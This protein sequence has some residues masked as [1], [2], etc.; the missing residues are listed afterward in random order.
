VLATN[1]KDRALNAESENV[2]ALM[3]LKTRNKEEYRAPIK[4]NERQVDRMQEL[5]GQWS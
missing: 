2:S 3:G 5:G 4:C 1:A